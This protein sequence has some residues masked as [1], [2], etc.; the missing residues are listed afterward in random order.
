MPKKKAEPTEADE[1]ADKEPEQEPK[2]QAP[3]EEEEAAK[4][5]AEKKAADLVYTLDL[6]KWLWS[7]APLVPDVEPD[8]VSLRDKKIATLKSMG[9]PV[10]FAESIGRPNSVFADWSLPGVKGEAPT[11][12]QKFTTTI[13]KNKLYVYG[14]ASPANEWYDDVYELDIAAK[15]WRRLYA[16]AIDSKVAAGRY[17]VWCGYTLVSLSKG[18]VGDALDVAMVLNVEPMLSPKNADFKST[19]TAYVSKELIELG[20][21]VTTMSAAVNTAV[22]EGDTAALHKVM[23]GLQGVR[24]NER[25]L[26]YTMDQLNDMLAY[27]KSRSMGKTE[28][29]QKKLDEVAEVFVTTARAAPQVKKQVKPV[30]DAEA[31]RVLDSIRAFEEQ[32]RK[33][34]ARLKAGKVFSSDVDY[35]AAYKLCQEEHLKLSE[36]EIQMS[37]IN[38]LAEL[39]EFPQKTEAVRELMGSMRDDLLTVKSVWDL[40]CIVQSQ[41]EVWKKVLW[42]EINPGKMEEESK[43]FTKMVRGLDKSVRSW[44]CYLN[45]DQMVKNFLVSVPCVADLK[46]PSMRDRRTRTPSL[47]PPPTARFSSLSGRQANAMISIGETREGRHVWRTFVERASSSHSKAP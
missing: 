29:L 43:V 27:M 18:M 31:L 25:Q 46:S 30:Q 39:F 32:L 37:K 28:P 36:L 24:N 15:V 13:I 10:E 44:P 20:A 8:F 42:E 17:N 22:P 23:R 16:C 1:E 11:P 4:A 7:S 26:E 41:I 14:G 40:T 2:P 34:Q 6:S 21:T 9:L 3:K 19:M 12:R 33:E 38:D 47:R 35:A 45:V 5:E